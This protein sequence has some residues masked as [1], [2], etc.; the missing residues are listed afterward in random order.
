MAVVVVVPSVSVLV[1]VVV[2]SAFMAVVVVVPSVSV[3]VDVVA[4]VAVVAVPSTGPVSPTLVPPVP[5]GPLS[6]TAVS[7]AEV[8]P[9][10]LGSNACISLYV[11][12]RS[13]L[14]ANAKSATSTYVIGNCPNLFFRT[15]YA[16]RSISESRS[17]SLLVTLI[18]LWRSTLS[19]GL[20]CSISPAVS[21]SLSNI[22]LSGRKT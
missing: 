17:L 15:G 13:V 20:P 1:V 18:T 3:V 5:P 22:A 8:P 16:S 6:P 4:V 10:P 11:L 21:K 2:P 9:A 7:L 14:S 12:S 19:K